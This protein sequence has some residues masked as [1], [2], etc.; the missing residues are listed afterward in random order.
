M[1]NESQRIQQQGRIFQVGQETGSVEGKCGQ[2]EGK[3][4]GNNP[5]WKQ[6][7]TCKGCGNQFHGKKNTTNQFC[8]QECQHLWVVNKWLPCSI[9]LANLG[10]GCNTVSK[11]VGVASPNVSR[12][13]KQR[14][15]VP[16]KPRSGSW[17]SEIG[18][19]KT[20]ENDKEKAIWRKYE[21]AWINEI[22]SHGK[23]FDW[24]ILWVRHRANKKEN[25]TYY[26]PESYYERACYR[27]IWMHSR[28]SIY[29]DWSAFWYRSRM[30]MS[31]EQKI[32]DNM[33]TRLK[34]LI[35]TTKKGGSSTVSGFIGCTTKQLAKHLESQFNKGMTWTNYGT[36]WHVDHILPCASFDH[37]DPKQVK[38]CW[39]WTNLR[40]L[41]AQRN[42]DKGATITEPQMQLLLCATH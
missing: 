41:E 39:H 37:T 40:P 22:L 2:G 33:R 5:K 12:G 28:Q 25:Q 21:S 13:W 18:K 9:C 16:L 23:M 6:L 35:K 26:S 10:F 19:I 38:Q 4:G 8:K 30:S 1:T 32:V 15:I 11:L 27:S 42:M 31:T 7:F 14:G 3:A 36:H 34:A 17:K 20:A 24:S 29:P